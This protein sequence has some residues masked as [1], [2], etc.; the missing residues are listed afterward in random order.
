VKARRD[1]E[2]IPN[3]GKLVLGWD[4]GVFDRRKVNEA[5]INVDLIDGRGRR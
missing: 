5:G 1:G 4:R 3:I 2:E